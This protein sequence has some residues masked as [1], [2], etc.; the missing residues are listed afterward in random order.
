[1]KVARTIPT[2]HG[3]KDVCDLIP[4]G[5]FMSCM[6]IWRLSL[7]FYRTEI[8]ELKRRLVMELAI[9][10]DDPLA[11]RVSVIMEGPAQITFP[12][13]RQILGLDFDDIR[14]RGL[15]DL[16]WRA[17]D[18]EMSGFEALFC[19]VRFERRSGTEQ[20]P[21]GRAYSPPLRFNVGQKTA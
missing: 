9:D 14:D 5:T 15:E 11:D 16:R 6:E 12:Y 10:I 1:M 4:S 18:Y 19:T 8:D 2:L 13:S 20:A 17:Y 7:E 21:Q 3:Y